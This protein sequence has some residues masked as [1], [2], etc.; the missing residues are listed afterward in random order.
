MSAMC[1]SIDG[2]TSQVLDSMFW[3]GMHA[4]DV[5]AFQALATTATANKDS[6][7]ED[8]AAIAQAAQKLQ[9][10]LSRAA[11]LRAQREP[12]A[13]RNGNGACW[14]GG[15]GLAAVVK[16]S[17]VLKQSLWGRLQRWDQH[18][19]CEIVLL[20]S[21]MNPSHWLPVP[22]VGGLDFRSTQLMKQTGPTENLQTLNSWLKAA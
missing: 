14:L 18:W 22:A 4:G 13:A 9:P 12:L 8:V 7:M 15:A 3:L 10:L 19:Q 1:L 16:S 11:Q 5:S 17:S 20:K 6:V 2:S 21:G